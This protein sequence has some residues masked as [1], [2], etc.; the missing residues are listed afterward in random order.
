[1][2][3]LVIDD[4]AP[5]RDAVSYHLRREGFE[6]ITAD[7]APDGLSTFRETRP[8]LIILDVMLPSGSGLD[9]CRLVRAESNVPII[10]LTSRTDEF[11]RVHGL[12]LGADDYVVKP[13]SLRELSARVRGLL[14]RSATPGDSEP[15]LVVIDGLTIDVDRC[16]ADANGRGVDL[17][18]RAVSLLHFLASHRGQA[19]SRSTL[20]SRVWGDDIGITERTVDVHV[21]WIRE[22]IEPQPSNP[23]Y[24]LTVRGVGYKFQG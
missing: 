9:V 21:H 4:E 8:R 19:F 12:N 3:V 11:D 23:R 18:P 7:D 15:R 14:R 2:R 5:I 17:S 13:F 24:I 16:R 20:L 6:V 22:R 10:L 1:M